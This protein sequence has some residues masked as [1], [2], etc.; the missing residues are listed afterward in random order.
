[1]AAL[2]STPVRL[3]VTAGVL[4]LLAA[5]IDMG[6][7]ARAMRGLDPGHGL[8]VLALLAGDRLVMVLRW[9]L[10]LRASGTRVPAADATS[11]YFVSSFVGGFLPAGVGGDVLRAYALGRQTAQ[12]G[13]AFA[14]VTVDRVLGLLSLVLTGILGAVLWSGAGAD[15]LQ[16][17]VVMIAVLGAVALTALFW[18]D[19]ALRSALPASWQRGP[20]AGPVLRV[21]D[22]LGRYRGRAGVLTSVLL[23]SLAVQGLRIGQAW[24][25]GVGIGIDVGF[26]YYLVFM[27]VGLL[28]LLLP[29]SISGF[30]LP[31]GV[32]V[33]L[34]QPRGVPE[35]L[36]FA[37]STLIVLSGII[38]NLP[39]AVL[40]LRARRRV[41]R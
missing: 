18:A 29:I 41:P 2:G 9:I 16:T 36:A 40:Y 19:R 33:W 20:V 5:R 22:A 31:Q 35:S 11:I 8:A 30:G 17:A 38:G 3:L 12:H 1:M 34:L 28:M 6:E 27:P 10:L 23:L 37:L 14:S 25:L 13:E 15:R 39:G 4:A 26:S 21:A 7:A 32:I 24:L